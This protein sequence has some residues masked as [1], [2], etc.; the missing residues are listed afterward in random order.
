MPG[1]PSRFVNVEAAR[2]RFGASIDRLE[3]LFWVADPLADA[4]VEAFERLPPGTG[5]RM[6]DTALR[7]GIE[8][9]AGAPEALRAL[10]AEVDHVPAWVDDEALERGGELLLRSGWFGGLALGTSL[11]YGYAS[12]G[13]NKPLAFSGRLTQQTPRRLVETSRFVEATCVPGGLSRFAEGF[14]ITVRVRVVHAKVRRMLLSSD[15]WSSRDWGLPASQHDMG[16]TSLLFSAVVI[17]TLER[18]GFDFDPEEVHL[19]MQLWRYSGYLMGVDPEILPTSEREARRLMDMVAATEAEPDEDS[20]RLSRALFATGE[21]PPRATKEEKRRATRVVH[22]G[23][24]LIRGVLGDELADQLD[25]PDHRW[26]HAFPAVRALTRGVESAMRNAPSPLARRLR[27]DAIATGRGY[28]AMLTRA[29]GEP[30]TFI[31]PDELFGAAAAAA[32]I[33]APRGRT[34]LAASVR[35]R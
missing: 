35:A 14:A 15:R 12:P 32:R 31:P 26:K 29:A 17:E 10:F 19:Y 5:S 16:S 33:V 4:V 34:P 21:D 27:R 28:W 7:Q 8:A 18:V 2:A 20:R 23:Q 3:D 22:L 11:L 1:R 25:V 30:L 13:G 24:G 9:A 6:L